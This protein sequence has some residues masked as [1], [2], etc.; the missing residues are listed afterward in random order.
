MPQRHVV[1]TTPL[2]VLLSGDQTA[3]T[4]FFVL[5]SKLSNVW[6]AAVVVKVVCVKHFCQ[7]KH[8]WRWLAALH[9]LGPV[10]NHL[11]AARSCMSRD[12]EA[13]K[14]KACSQSCSHDA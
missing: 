13:H 4:A 2:V 1:Q 3:V 10:A 7:A 11:S 12:M 8:Q 5:L 14:Y 6:F 9:G